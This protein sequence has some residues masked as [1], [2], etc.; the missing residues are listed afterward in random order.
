M[1]I[2]FIDV[3]H[4]ILR[5][6]N[7]LAKVSGNLSNLIAQKAEIHSSNK[8]RVKIKKD[9]SAKSQVLFETKALWPNN[10]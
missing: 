2:Y 9:F 1:R 8:G 7:D 6:T 3:F 10:V 5:W 4:S